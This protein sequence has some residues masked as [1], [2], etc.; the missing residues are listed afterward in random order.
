MNHHNHHNYHFTT[1][2]DIV[3]KWSGDTYNFY[4]V[5]NVDRLQPVPGAVG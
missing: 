1:F 5:G 4:F 3:I 2:Q